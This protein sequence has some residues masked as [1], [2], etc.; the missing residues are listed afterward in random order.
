M[1]KVIPLLL[2][3]FLFTGCG[4][5]TETSSSY[6]QISMEEAVSMMEKEDS[7]I[8]LDVRTVEEFEERHIPGAINIPNETISSEEIPELPDKN[9]LILVYC[10]SGNRSKQASQKLA[11]Q[12]YTNIVEFGGIND[13]TGET[14]SGLS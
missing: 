9:Q 13:W 8:L 10:R 4:A 5:S 12:G 3:L 14:V 6:Q 11:Q 1:K 7:Y 2:L